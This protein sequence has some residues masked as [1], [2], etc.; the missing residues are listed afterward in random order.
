MNLKILKLAHV[1]IFS[2]DLKKV[3]NFYIKLLKLKIIFTFKNEKNK[4]Y[5]FFLNSGGGTLLEFFKT[6]RKYLRKGRINHICL[7]V[8]NIE[9]ASKFLTKK[10]IKFKKLTSKK[11]KTKHIKLKDFE[12]NLIEL[13]EIMDIKSKISKY[14]NEKRL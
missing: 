7:L 14:Y 1:S 12:N 4:I 5:G 11:D 13:H 6:K 10:G 8:N 2:F 3:E 9:H